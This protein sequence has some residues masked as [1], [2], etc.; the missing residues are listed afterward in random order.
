MLNNDV[1]GEYIKQ[2]FIK[3]IQRN[4]DLT[5]F[6]KKISQFFSLTRDF[7]FDQNKFPERVN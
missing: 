3:R 1:K 5:N 7:S 4:E 2:E 6:K